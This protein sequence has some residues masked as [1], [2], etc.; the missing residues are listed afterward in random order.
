VADVST[1]LQV[2]HFT[3]FLWNGFLSA[4]MKDSAGNTDVLHA[5]HCEDAGGAVHPIL[6]MLAVN[7]WT[8]DYTTGQ[9]IFKT[10]LWLGR[11][12]KG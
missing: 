7:D 1:L 3:H 2:L 9:G 12:E 5:G 4:A 8:M 10:S 6:I 11:Q